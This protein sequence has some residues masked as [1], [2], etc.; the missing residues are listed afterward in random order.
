[1]MPKGA[2]KNTKCIPLCEWPN[3]TGNCNVGRLWVIFPL[4]SHTHKPGHAERQEWPLCGHD[5]E[6]TVHTVCHC[7]VLAC[8]RYRILG[9]M[10]LKPEDLEKVRVG[11]LLSQHRAWLGP[12][13]LLT[14]EEIQWNSNDLGIVRIRQETLAIFTTTTTTTT[15]LYVIT[16][17]K[18][19]FT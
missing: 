1:M 11:S 10:I 15:T 13:T 18:V 2:T 8:K 17:T 7:P 12:L 14:S 9:W 19:M 16:V 3:Q 6:D 4:F 5:K